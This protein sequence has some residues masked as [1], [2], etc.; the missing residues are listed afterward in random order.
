MEDHRK[1]K[2][3]HDIESKEDKTEEVPME[4]DYIN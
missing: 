2:S 3:L 4:L 1:I